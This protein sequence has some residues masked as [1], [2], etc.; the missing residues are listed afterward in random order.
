VKRRSL[1]ARRRR[2]QDL[3]NHRVDERDRQR[4]R[5]KKLRKGTSARRF[6]APVSAQLSRA[7]LPL[8]AADLQEIILKNWDRQSRLSRASFR[9]DLEGLL[10]LSG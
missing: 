5:R 9:R 2:E 7:G 6:S 4:R 1:L 8:Q 3:Q 10:G